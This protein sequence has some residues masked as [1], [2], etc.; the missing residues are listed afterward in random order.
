MYE[1]AV[2]RGITYFFQCEST[3]QTS[4]PEAKFKQHIQSLQSTS[5]LRMR[6]VTVPKGA[7]TVEGF[8]EYELMLMQ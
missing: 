2:S 6:T 5:R 1:V 8:C 3:G 7:V 4:V